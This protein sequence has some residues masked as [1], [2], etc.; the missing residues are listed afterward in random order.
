MRRDGYVPIR[1]YAA[2]GDG[3][4]VALVA[5]DGAI[6]WLCLPD[7]DSPS[8]F[9]AL[10]D[11][12]GGGSFAVTPAGSFEAD[13]RYREHSNVLET[14]FH[15]AAGVARVTDGMALGSSDGLTPLREIVRSVECIEGEVE[16]GWH[17][18]PRL[19][20]AQRTCRFEQR[21]D[22]VLAE[23]RG[24]A[25]VLAAWGAGETATDDGR[26]SGTF[27]L[28]AGEAALFSLTA[29]GRHPA[30]LV[31]R[32][33]AA[34]R[35]DEADR[36]WREWT[37]TLQYDGPWRDAV[38]RSALALRLLVY[39]P[40]GAIVAAATTSLPEELGGSRNWDY[41]YTWLRDAAFTLDAFTALGCEEEARAF[42]W[43]LMHA[44]RLTQPR[45]QVLYGVDGGIEADEVELD[46]LHGY[47]GS[48]PVRVGNGASEQVQLDV[49]GSILD[50]AW[51]HFRAHGDLGGETGKA[52]AKIADYVAE[53]W[54]DP[55][56][57]IWE[58]RSEPTNFIQS[59][60]M[61]WVALDRAARLADEGV[62]PDR[63]R[64]W[65]REAE[66]IRR[67]IDTE[68]WD[69]GM[70]SYVRAT[71][72]QELDAS[73]L[74]LPIV[75]FDG[76]PRVAATV[77][78]VRRELARGPFVQRYR[79]QDGVEGEDAPFLTC[80]FWLVDALARLGRLGEARELMDELVGLAN[81]VGLYA[82]EIDA[83]SREFL[84]NFP[85]ALVHLA[86]IN[87]AVSITKREG[88][89]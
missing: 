76:G 25:I 73:L 41:R 23:A 56:S 18:E 26:I 62:L 15:A 1:D 89:S 58:V 7:I 82:E 83:E 8:V 78:A 81:D 80:S 40:S 30:V 17:F 65:R 63:S 48:S 24:S 46:H 86:L 12:E 54:R 64:D 49:Y 13:R 70:R 71:D 5:R 31:G 28:A 77:D 35:L 6:D 21:G 27:S 85:Q 47:R 79:G 69:E 10:L 32:D 34:A 68:G 37:G 2:I 75:G 29:T 43:W 74:L 22:A 88:A 53:H 20:Y 36:F 9:A 60:A 19:D 44:T 45:L 11:A 61:C 38:L 84:G 14:T 16:L 39:A 55:D 67:F 52:V 72:L 42:F 51:G 59:K 50:A 66:K 87:A 33:D 3:R 4:T 57:G